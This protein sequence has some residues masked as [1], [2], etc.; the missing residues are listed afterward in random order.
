MTNLIFSILLSLAA[1]LCLWA[2]V[3]FSSEQEAAAF[4]RLCGGDATAWDAL[5]T[6][7]RVDGECLRRSRKP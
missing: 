2:F 7:L 5:F 4:N 6:E 1:L 3:W